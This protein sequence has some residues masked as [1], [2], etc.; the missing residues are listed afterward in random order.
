[1]PPMP[2]AA[3]RL[4]APV[5]I[6]ATRTCG[7]SAPIRMM[8]PLPHVFSICVMARVSALRR[9]SVSLVGCGCSAMIDLDMGGGLRLVWIPEYIPNPRLAPSWSE[10]V[11]QVLYLIVNNGD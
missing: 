2:I 7:E 8:E 6:P 4:I 9:S 5:E 3:S 1:M 10:G 11:L